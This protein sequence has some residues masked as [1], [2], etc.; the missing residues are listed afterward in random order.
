MA[1]GMIPHPDF[2]FRRYQPGDVI[3]IP[4]LSIA[5]MGREAA[6]AAEYAMRDA[7][8]RA[9]FKDFRSEFNQSSDEYR[10]TFGER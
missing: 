7:A 3:V 1:N 2:D 9:G 5:Q 10:I 4:M 8:R 6:E